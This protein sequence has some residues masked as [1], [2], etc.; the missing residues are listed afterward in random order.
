MHNFKELKI[1]KA[2]IE[3]SKF[4]FNI[5]RNFPPDERYGLISQMTRAAVSIPSNIAEG[6]GRKSNKELHQFLNISLGS[7]FELETHFIIANEFAY[8]TEN[9]LKEATLMLAEIQKMIY[10]LQ[11]S[12]N[13]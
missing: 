11:K 9:Q 5:T 3:V 12:L 10:G 8:I 2:G 6:C 13:I 7:A 4:T 1:W